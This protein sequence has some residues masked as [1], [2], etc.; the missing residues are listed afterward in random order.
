VNL[1]QV[2]SPEITILSNPAGPRRSSLAASLAA[3][4]GSAPLTTV[5]D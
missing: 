2:T 3:T 5:S 4:T 1:V